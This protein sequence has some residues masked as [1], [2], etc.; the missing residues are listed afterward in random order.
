MESNLQGVIK[1]KDDFVSFYD[2]DLSVY[3]KWV[4]ESCVKLLLL[5]FI[6]LITGCASASPKQVEFREWQEEVKLNDGRVIVVKQKW[7]C[8]YIGKNPRGDYC[9]TM[10]EAWLTFNL[11][12]FSNHD[13]EWN[14]QLRPMVL[15]IDKGQLY[16]VGKFAIGAHQELWGNPR[17]P[18][19]G[20]RWDVDK[21]QQIP[22]HEI[23]EAIYTTNMATGFPPPESPLFFKFEAKIQSIRNPRISKDS[24]VIN[25]KLEFDAQLEI[26]TRRK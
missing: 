10:R 9:G 20:F 18:Y 12:E 8:D 3:K 13:I 5:I 22:F 24:K 14:E 1:I 17:H 6:L 15:N 21:W 19:I 26:Y 16:L 4:E 23:P 25:P 11:P 7:R 2:V